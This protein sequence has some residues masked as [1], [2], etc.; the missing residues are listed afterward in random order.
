M[1][2]RRLSQNRSGLGSDKMR[3]ERAEDKVKDANV[4]TYGKCRIRINVVNKVKLLRQEKRENPRMTE[5]ML[6]DAH[7]RHDVFLTP[8]SRSAC[9]RGF[10]NTLGRKRSSSG[11]EVDESLKMWQC[12]DDEDETGLRLKR[13]EVDLG[14]F[15]FGHEALERNSV[16]PGWLEKEIPEQILDGVVNVGKGNKYLTHMPISRVHRECTCNYVPV[17]IYQKG[18][19]QAEVGTRELTLF[20]R[21]GFCPA[22]LN[23]PRR[24]DPVLTVYIHR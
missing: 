5:D 20:I 11:E 19:R 3:L 15:L 14:S 10:M 16:V 21:G 23:I 12:A 17:S 8:C 6:L 9:D 22:Q 24:W 18:S 7:R 2:A 1:V 4:K 13:C